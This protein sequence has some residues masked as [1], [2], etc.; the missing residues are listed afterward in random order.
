MF[1]GRDFP[2]RRGSICGSR[3]VYLSTGDGKVFVFH[4]DTPGKYSVAQEI[5]T[6]MGAKTMRIEPKTGNLFVPT[7]DN[8]AMQLLLLPDKP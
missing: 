4:Q 8:S 3:L 1:S 7:S 5:T 2:A 6:R